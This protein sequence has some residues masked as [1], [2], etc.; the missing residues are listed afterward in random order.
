MVRGTKVTPELHL[1]K[2]ARFAATADRLHPEEDY[3]EIMRVGMH[4]CTHWT[5]AVFHARGLT[6]IE[7]HFEHSWYIDRCPDTNKVLAGIG[8]QLA[9]LLDALAVFKGLRTAYVR[10][11]GPFGPDV[12]ARSQVALN[13]VRDVT[14]EVFGEL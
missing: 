5:N 1:S 12:L 8:D 2:A 3:E 13:S 14:I 4:M 7:F 10:C 6:S 9:G 11:P